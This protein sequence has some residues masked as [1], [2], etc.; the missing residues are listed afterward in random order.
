[1][2]PE[3]AGEPAAPRRSRRDH[4]MDRNLWRRFWRVLLTGLVFLWIFS[5]IMKITTRGPDWIIVMDISATLT[6]ILAVS[7]LA[8]WWLRKVR[9][10]RSRRTE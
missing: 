9:C 4:D 2:G 8:L 1:M 3:R 5:G 10:N 7:M 6:I